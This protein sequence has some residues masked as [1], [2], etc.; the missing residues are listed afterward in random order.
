MHILSYLKLIHKYC[1]L[2]KAIWQKQNTTL[3]IQENSP[4]SLLHNQSSILYSS[5]KAHQFISV[6]LYGRF[7]FFIAIWLIHIRTDMI[8]FISSTKTPPSYRI[9][10]YPLAPKSNIGKVLIAIIR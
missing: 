6:F 4:S 9:R 10:A 1:S 7:S 3:E 2:I 5:A 8:S